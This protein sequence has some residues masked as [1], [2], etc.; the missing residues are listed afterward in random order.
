MAFG[1]GQ[2]HGVPPRAGAPAI[3]SEPA[4]ST[5]HPEFLARL[6][7]STGGQVF[8]DGE[9]AAAGLQALAAGSL[10]LPARQ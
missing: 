9:A 8:K 3:G 1:D 4:V 5:A 7:H 10:P 2:P 6:A